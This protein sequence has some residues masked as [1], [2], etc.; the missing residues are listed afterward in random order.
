MF[1]TQPLAYEPGAAILDVSETLV[2]TALK[3]IFIPGQ[4]AECWVAYSPHGKAAYVVDAFQANVTVVDTESGDVRARFG[5]PARAAGGV[6]AAIDRGRLYLL[7]DD[8]VAPKVNV[9]KLR[10]RDAE[11]PAM[12]VQSLD[13]YGTVG[14]IGTA[15]GMAIYPS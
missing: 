9:F 5:Y 10:E 15:N 7:T 1:I 2:V 4:L 3:D 12:L 11:E 13:I 14:S 8:V 6:D